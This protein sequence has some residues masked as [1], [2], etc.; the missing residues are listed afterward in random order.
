MVALTASAS[1]QPDQG[2]EL[3]DRGLAAAQRG[4]Q[5]EAQR[6]YGQALR[7]F[8][9]G[10]PQFESHVA[11]VL[12]NLGESLCASGRRAEAVP[13]YE[14]ALA[15]NR[16]VLGPKHIR[17]LNNM[18]VLAT[19]YLLLGEVERAEPLLTEALATE[20][21]LYPNDLELAH[22]LAGLAAL[23]SRQGKPA[24]AL[25]LA[26]EALSLA[27]RVA[28]EES[29]D[30][31][32]MYASVAELHRQAGRPE[33]ALPLY[34]KSRA[35][36]E[37]ILG[38]QHPRVASIL[39]QE[40]LALMQDGKLSLADEEMTRADDL[41]ARYC[42]GCLSER[43]L[44]RHNLG[45]LRMRQHR[46]AEADRLLTGALAMEEQASARPGR[47]MANTLEMLALV[48]EKE[49]RHEDA[50]LLKSRASVILAYQ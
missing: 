21:E 22:T 46:Y 9:A 12:V 20:R 30:T 19:A 13:G 1:A 29:A 41:L 28:G 17:S 35:I 37:R 38:A 24:E 45:L 5:A 32:L 18:N 14:E 47:D 27:L 4:D 44:S 2:M 25:P 3:N 50:V 7:I 26:E 36:C 48:R 43:A 23:R 34:R 42:L 33:R 39:S 31:A 49:K 11:A 40:G 16:R 8:R 10:G 6:L 15:V